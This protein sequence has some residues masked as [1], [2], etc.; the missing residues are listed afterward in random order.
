V[1]KK[2]RRMSKNVAALDKLLELRSERTKARI[3]ASACGTPQDFRA[4]EK[5]ESEYEEGY[6]A[7]VECLKKLDGGK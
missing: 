3:D 2:E 4:L 1:L 6:E 7:F 5:A